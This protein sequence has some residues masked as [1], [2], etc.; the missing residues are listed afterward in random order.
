MWSRRWTGNN[1]SSQIDWFLNGQKEKKTIGWYLTNNSFL[2]IIWSFPV[3]LLLSFRSESMRWEFQKILPDPESPQRGLF[4]ASR[5]SCFVLCLTKRWNWFFCRFDG[6]ML[7][8]H[9]VVTNA[10]VCQNVGKGG[11]SI[12]TRSIKN[13]KSGQSFPEAKTKRKRWM[14]SETV[15]LFGI[16]CFWED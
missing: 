7:C 16:T 9:F 4:W 1:F 6:C 12:R 14:R 3:L 15:T 11:L 13:G 2:P 8:L 10:L 5:A